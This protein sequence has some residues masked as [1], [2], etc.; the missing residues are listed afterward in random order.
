MHNTLCYGEIVAKISANLNKNTAHKPR[1]E[2]ALSQ[3]RL[4]RD[5]TIW[6]LCADAARVFDALE[7][8]SGDLPIDWHHA[9]DEYSFEV[10][11]FLLSGRKPD[12][13]NMFSMASHCLEKSR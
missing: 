6:T 5:E 11:T 12:Y 2:Y 8:L 9:L 1:I 4:N 3:G 10:L 13:V 7:D